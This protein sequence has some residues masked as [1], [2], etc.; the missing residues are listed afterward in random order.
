M[1]TDYDVV[2]IGEALLEISTRSTPRQGTPARLAFSGDALNQAAAAAAAGAHVGLLT[3]VGDDAIGEGLLQR[4]TDLGVDTGLVHVVAESNGAYLTQADPAG[5][6]AFSYLRGAS[7]ASR[8]GPADVEHDAVRRAS[9]ILCSG[10]T[11]GISAS[12]R[13]TVVAA[14]RM[15]RNFVYDPNHRPALV[16]AATAADTLRKVAPDSVVTPSHPAESSALLGGT[17]PQAAARQLLGWGARAAVVTCGAD[18]AFLAA[19]D[20]VDH[21]SAVPAVKVIDQTGAGDVF[22]GTLTAR[23][24]LGDSLWDATTLA[25]AAASL[26]VQGRGGTGHIPA[27]AETRAHLAASRAEVG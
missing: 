15:A 11:A 18:G 26:S 10:I 27:L 23:L 24:A 3:R 6:R 8:L 5:R 12:A 9:H 4:V 17:D 19:G 25:L 2:V 22:A 7:A 21:L 16:D 1:R 20:R 14:H 13:A